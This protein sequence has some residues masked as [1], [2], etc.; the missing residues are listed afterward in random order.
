MTTTT[1]TL[2][3]CQRYADG[4][5][6]DLADLRDLCDLWDECGGDLEQVQASLADYEE[7]DR[8]RLSDML[9]DFGYEVEDMGPAGAWV[10]AR[11]LELVVKWSGGLGES[12]EPEAVEVAVTLGGPNVYVRSEDERGRFVVS[13]YWASDRAERVVYCAP[14]AGYL[15]DVVEASR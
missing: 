12:P 11:A 9:D 10:E 7:D 14:L 15:W 2:T 5:A 1:D 3:D 8:K 6:L 4:L 13:V